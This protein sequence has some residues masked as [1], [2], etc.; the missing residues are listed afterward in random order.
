VTP[1]KSAGA[2]PQ[3][4]VVDSNSD[5][6]TPSLVC[7]SDSGP[8][9]SI[10]SQVLLSTPVSCATVTVAFPTRNTGAGNCIIGARE[11]HKARASQRVLRSLVVHLERLTMT[12]SC[13]LSFYTLAQQAWP[14]MPS[15]SSSAQYA[16]L[17]KPW[18]WRYISTEPW[19]GEAAQVQGLSWDLAP[20]H[21]HKALE[22][23]GAIQVPRTMPYTI[24]P[25]GTAMLPGMDFP[26]KNDVNRLAAGA[27][28]MWLSIFIPHPPMNAVST[29]PR[30]AS[31]GEKGIIIFFLFSAEHGQTHPCQIS[32]FRSSCEPQDV[33]A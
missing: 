9:R 22:I 13:L 8:S 12:D 26:P 3:P 7:F 31:A 29:L 23:Y 15:S 25:A 5:L 10:V 28:P 32:G 19:E 24:L 16:R 6:F 1:P 18:P 2:T 14:H 17:M 27:S 20:T 21:Q 33:I 30:S 4:R 11:G